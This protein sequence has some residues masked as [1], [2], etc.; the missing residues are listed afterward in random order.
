MSTQKRIY[1]AKYHM[2]GAFFNKLVH[3]LAPHRNEI[4]LIDRYPKQGHSS[5]D[6]TAQFYHRQRHN[7]NRSDPVECQRA[8]VGIHLDRTQ[9]G[10]IIVDDK[11]VKSCPR[12]KDLALVNDRAIQFYTIAATVVC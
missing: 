8:Q 12:L 3:L 11:I 10:F 1:F 9:L 7:P 4:E 2:S 6:K 5:G